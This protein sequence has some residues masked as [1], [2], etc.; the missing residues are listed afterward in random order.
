MLRSALTT[1]DSPVYSVV[2]GADSDQMC[3]C[4]GSS[5]VIRSI[6]TSAKQTAWKAHD[7][8]V[9]KVDWSPI[10]H[11][12]I[13]GGEDCRYKASVLYCCYQRHKHA[14]CGMLSNN[15]MQHALEQSHATL[16]CPPQVAPSHA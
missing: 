11:M 10:N 5:I 8:V 16:T 6:Q 12:I 3:Y 9:L 4:T 2:W 14:A 15:R 1:C 7:G 13:S